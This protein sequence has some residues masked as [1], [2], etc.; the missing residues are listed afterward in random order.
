M[1]ASGPASSPV[2]GSASQDLYSTVSSASPSTADRSTPTTPAKT[3]SKDTPL[4]TVFAADRYT[5]ARAS[6]SGEI[7]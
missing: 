7:V 4:S 2:A 6:M 1:D 3:A 5:N